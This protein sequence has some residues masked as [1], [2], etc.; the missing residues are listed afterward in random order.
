M[1]S[2]PSH[3]EILGIP[4]DATHEEIRRAYRE[5]SLRVHPDVN[6]SPGANSQFMNLKEAFETLTNPSRRKE[7]DSKLSQESN[8]PVLEDALYSRSRLPDLK[9][10]QLLYT[11]LDFSVSPK[12]ASQTTPTLNFCIILDRSTSMQGERLDTVKAAAIEVIRQSQEANVLS[13]VTFSDRAEV[14][15]PAKRYTDMRSIENQIH[16]IQASGG[17][18]IYQG[19]EAGFQQIQ[20]NLNRALVNHIILITDGHTYGDELACLEL[21][22]RAAA[23]GVRITA[24]GIGSDWNDN[25]L[26]T[27]TQITGG[28]TH[29]IS[30]TSDLRKLMNEKFASLNQVFAE[31]VTLKLKLAPRVALNSL[32][33]IQPDAAPLPKEESIVLGSILRDTS[34][35]VLLEFIVQPM[36]EKAYRR[37]V[38]SGTLNL[39]LPS[40]PSVT[41]HLPVALSRLVGDLE[42]NEKP[43]PEI[44]QAMTHI[45]LYRMQE[46]AREEVAVGKVD[47]ASSRLQRLATQFLTLGEKDLAQTAMMEAARIQQTSMLSAEGEKA[48]KYATR[49]L[50]LPRKA[51]AERQN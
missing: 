19:L 7:Y 11:L 6:R 12:Y 36:D 42:K 28:N 37:Q 20:W 31:R 27:I 24:L 51:K 34:L 25:F 33:R 40:D 18:E 9:E 13:I 47:E 16:F 45:T 17:T 15:L 1:A 8:E 48:I 2:T 49:S 38:A 35:S 39:I 26:D 50:L 43:P 22:N 29:Y 46:R 41:F 4:K 10:P 44:I 5:L 14:I 30:K 32:F 23:Q 21:A 3:Y